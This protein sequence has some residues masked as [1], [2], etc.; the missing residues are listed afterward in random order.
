[1]F[2][3][4]TDA[5]ADEE[6]VKVRRFGRFEMVERAPRP[7]RDLATGD[8]LMVGRHRSVAFRPS[9]HLRDALGAAL[10]DPETP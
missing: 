2:S 1:V 7:A 5:L 6:P 10:L 8:P 3:A 9:P 4:I